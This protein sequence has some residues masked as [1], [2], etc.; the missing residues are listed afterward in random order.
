LAASLGLFAAGALLGCAARQGTTP[1]VAR[2]R[3]G[4]VTA[5]EL[6][7]YI[8]T[9]PAAGGAFAGPAERRVRLEELLALRAAEH[10]AETSGILEDPRRAAELRR[11]TES[12]LIAEVRSRLEAE[13]DQAAAAISEAQVDAAYAASPFAA[14]PRER[15]RLRH[16]FKRLPRGAGMDERARIE[17]TMEGILAEL[18][19]GADFRTLA[20]SR[21][22][23]QTASFDGLM[24]P[25][26]RGDLDPALEE[27]L[28]RL[29]PGERTGIVR[30]AAGLQIFLLEGRETAPA[31]PV[32]DA[33]RVIRLR[34]ERQAREEHGRRRLTGMAKAQGADF[35]PA[36]LDDD[37][38]P[39]DAV[40]FEM[41]GE[42]LTVGDLRRR[43]QERPFVGRRTG[44]LRSVLEEEAAR[45]LLLHEA[46]AE[47][48]E[49]RPEVAAR[50]S[51]V[52]RSFLVEVVGDRRAEEL[53]ASVD[54]AEPERLYLAERHLFHRPETRRLRGIVVRLSDAREANATF[55]ALDLLAREVRAGET[56]LAAAAREASDDPSGSEGGDLGW[57]DAKDL[58]VWA[59][60]RVAT[61]VFGLTQGEVGAPLL[62]ESYDDQRLVY[63]PQACLL[64]RVE[65]IRAE[66]ATPFLEARPAVLQRYRTL[67]AADIGRRVRAGLLAAIDAVI[68]ERP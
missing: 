20:R 68:L 19:A 44:T 27:L 38:A 23:S 30:T 53:T 7:R 56:D 11:R 59:G 22:D 39:H 5:S 49:A 17:R 58:A 40:A 31:T 34:L 37:Q 54:D 36:I 51:D 52:R 64:V 18:G 25:V 67:H 15:L 24:A 57:A 2:S 42:R 1:I 29:A 45:L 4:P 46:R 41:H 60:S 14:A 43:W 66:G 48:L 16:I 65:D 6:D 32:A 47:R 35:R 9:R 61:A 33:K 62:V 63:V 8:A 13:A 50:L 55:D 26:G 21:S 10:E 3:L 28:W 12:L